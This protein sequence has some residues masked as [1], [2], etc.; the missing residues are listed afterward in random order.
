[1][2]PLHRL[3][4][5]TEESRKPAEHQ[6]STLCLLSAE[7]NPATCT[8]LHHSEK[9]ARSQTVSQNNPPAASCQVCGHSNS[10]RIQ[11]KTGPTAVSPTKAFLLFSQEEYIRYQVWNQR[12]TATVL[13]TPVVWTECCCPA[14]PEDTSKATQ[15]H[16]AHHTQ[17]SVSMH[18]AEEACATLEA[19]PIMPT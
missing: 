18:R 15:K 17:P 2:G 14:H 8:R 4:N 5:Q 10:M 12:T 13:H 9:T 6:Y 19:L 7:A 3:G 1:M 11:L 16:K